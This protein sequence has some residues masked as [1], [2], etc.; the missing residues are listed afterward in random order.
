MGGLGDLLFFK[1]I[2]LKPYINL[3]KQSIN[4]LNTNSNTPIELIISSK[5]EFEV[6]G[7]IKAKAGAKI[8][9]SLIS[10]K[11][12]A[13]YTAIEIPVQNSTT[14]TCAE[15]GYSIC[16]KDEECSTNEL[17]YAKD[18]VCC[19]GTCKAKE[20]SSST[21][22]IIGISILIIVVILG[23]LFYKKFKKTKKPINLLKI[24]K[25]KKK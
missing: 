18:N 11:F 22:R 16:S 24:A 21:G 6:E 2:F 15:K 23:A 4:E 12:L 5:E 13:N 3:S 1:I 20:K 14:R 17:F 7:Y 8:V 9:Y 19:I 10:I 25:G